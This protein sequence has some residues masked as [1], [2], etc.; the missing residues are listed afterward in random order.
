MGKLLDEYKARKWSA[1]DKAAEIQNIDEKIE[2]I[3]TNI[4]QHSR[5]FDSAST[6]PYKKLIQA[7]LDRL[8]YEAN[9]WEN[10]KMYLKSV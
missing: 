5:L 10:V 4:E 2:G 3:T 9:E 6:E 7:T 1:K 8:M